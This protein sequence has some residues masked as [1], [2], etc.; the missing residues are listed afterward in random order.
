MDINLSRRYVFGMFAM[1]YFVQGVIQAYQLN[2]FKPHMDAEGID[3]DRLAIVASL[4]LLPFVIKWI[5]GLI[6]DRYNLFGRGHRVPY[7]QIG[8]VST[9]IAFFVAYFIDPSESFGLLA[10]MVLA[11]T[12]AMALFDTTA[13]ALAVDIVPPEDHSEVQA[14]MTGGRAAGLVVLSLAFGLIADSVG[15]QAIFLVI[16]ALLL[17]PLAMVR[18]VQEPA[19][20]TPAHEFDRSAFRVLLQPRYLV[21]G[22][23]LTLAWTAF[24]G[25]D[26]LV[27]FFMSNELESS[28]RTIGLYGSLKGI[29]MIVGAFGV[30]RIVHKAGRMTAALVTIGAVTAGGFAFSILSTER[31]I[32]IAAAFWG[33]AVGLQWT[34][35]VT[36][37]MGITDT[38]IAGSMFAIL[39]TMSNIGIGA[40]EGV[41]TALSDNLGFSGV[42]RLFAIANL[43][44]IPLVMFAVHRF[45]AMYARRDTGAIAE[46]L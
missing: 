44:V 20:R 18:R 7:M 30:H 3:A 12:F 37:S 4:A 23:V 36:L 32:L 31:A 28:G 40:G 46:V 15:Y 19:Q 45:A 34:T 22:V 5:Y 29:G 39:Q 9:A 25:I 42:F 10:T 8:L 13:D 21:F 35:Y 11:A 33:I 27:T 38:R 16:A 43:F 41:A 17:V 1:L 2:F 14:F 26:G 6:S 24:Q